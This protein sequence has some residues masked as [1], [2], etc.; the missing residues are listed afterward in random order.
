MVLSPPHAHHQQPA[1]PEGG[2]AAQ[3]HRG[4]KCSKMM[5]RADIR[6]Q[7]CMQCKHSFYVAGA[8]LLLAAWVM[9]TSL[10]LLDLQV[11]EGEHDQICRV[12]QLEL[13]C[14]LLLCPNCALL[15]QTARP[16]PCT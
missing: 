8:S 4:K 13:T 12:L 10:I 3:H 2:E 5:A 7:G 15:V 6:Q 9:C 14:A 16:S 11:A 1:P